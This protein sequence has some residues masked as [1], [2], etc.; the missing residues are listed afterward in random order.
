MV[1]PQ[2]PPQPQQNHENP[3]PV[4]RPSMIVGHLPS[5]AVEEGGR[6]FPDAWDLFRDKL[7]CVFRVNAVPVAQQRDWLLSCPGQNFKVVHLASSVGINDPQRRRRRLPEKHE[8]WRM[9]LRSVPSSA[10]AVIVGT[11]RLTIAA[12]RVQLVRTTQ[13]SLK[14]WNSTTL[15][16]LGQIKVTATLGRLSAT[17]P[18]LIMALPRPLLLG[19]QSF[20]ALGINPPTLAAAVLHAS[21]LETS[22]MDSTATVTA[23]P[24]QLNDFGRHVTIFVDHK[25][26]TGIF[27]GAGKPI[28]D[29]LS[30]RMLRLCLEAAAFNYTLVYREGKKHSNADFCSRFPVD[31]APPVSPEEP[32]IVMFVSAGQQSTSVFAQEIA[33]ETSVDPVLSQVV[34]AVES[35]TPKHKLPKEVRP[36]MVGPPGSLSVHMGCILFGAR[37][38][39][40]SSLRPKVLQHL[41]QFHQGMVRTKSVAR[42]YCWWPQINADIEYL[43]ASCEVC[44]VRQSDPPKLQPQQWPQTTRPMQRVHLDFFG[45]MFNLYFLIMVDAFSNW[46]ELSYGPNQDAATLITSSREWFSRLGLPDESVSDNGP[47]FRAEIYC[48]FLQNLGVKQTFSP[49]YHPASNGSAERAVRTIKALLS[50]LQG[51]WKQQLPGLLLTLRTTPTA[52]GHSPAELM[53]NRRLVTTF[54]RMHPNKIINPSPNVS[55]I[56]AWPIGSPIYY[57]QYLQRG[58]RGEKWLPGV[59]KGHEGT[60]I[61]TIQGPDGARVRRHLD[62]VRRRSPRTDS[63]PHSRLQDEK[64]AVAA[65]LA[66]AEAARE[67]MR[68]TRVTV[69]VSQTPALDPISVVHNQPTIQPQ[70]MSE[71]PELRRSERLRGNNNASSISGSVGQ[72]TPLARVA[73][74]GGR[75]SPLHRTRHSTRVVDSARP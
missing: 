60:R 27:R 67:Q 17:L 64:V 63:D 39:I 32:A 70:P 26:L 61:L 5:L 58:G 31:A 40:P 20:S 51:D 35:G 37:V 38:V 49:P 72:V 1:N 56:A 10:G 43:V 7:E 6:P 18:L 33:R 13:L 66:A 8:E 71:L 19:R 73:V 54:D 53:L 22:T 28:P 14:A 52:S 65:A 69:P 21:S 4:Q 74:R 57:R 55:D 3:P 41:H 30:P 23:Q 34:R 48:L 59:I 75:V 50:K 9:E 36:Y 29:V 24:E 68:R 2:P 25:P 15:P 42:S 46:L 44:A 12:T 62:Q 11:T 45:P 16:V 47:A